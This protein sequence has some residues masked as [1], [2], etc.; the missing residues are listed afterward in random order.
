MKQ[1]TLFKIWSVDELEKKSVRELVALADFY[2][3]FVEKKERRRMS[4][5][6]RRI[7]I[8]QISFKSCITQVNIVKGH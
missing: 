6:T 3:V 8:S 7:I 1:K 4:A 2:S 5:E